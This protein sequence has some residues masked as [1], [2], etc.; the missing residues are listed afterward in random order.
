MPLVVPKDT[1]AHSLKGI[2]GVCEVSA[3]KFFFVVGSQDMMTEKVAFSK[4]S[5][6]ETVFNKHHS[7]DRKCHLSVDKTPKWGEKIQFTSTMMRWPFKTNQ[8]NY[9]NLSLRL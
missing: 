9:S 5:S 6:L 2:N 1:S 3:F 8:S 7:G 4:M